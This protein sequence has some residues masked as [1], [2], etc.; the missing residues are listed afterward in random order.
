MVSVL[1]VCHGNICRSPMAEFIFKDLAQRAGLAS[2]F[3]IE[4]AATSTEELGSPVY[5]PARRKLAEHGL[6]CAGKRAR[7]LQRSDYRRFDLLIGM[8]WAN[9]LDIRRIVGGDP[10]A[11]VHLLLDYTDHPGDIDDPWYTSDF[12]TAWDEIE[13]GCIGLFHHLA[14]RLGKDET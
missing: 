5:L 14:N 7:Q 4:S 10:L 12:D 6:R 11:K 2:Q 13:A 8:D 3:V 9:L 1:F